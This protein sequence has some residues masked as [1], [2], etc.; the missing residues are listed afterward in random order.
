MTTNTTASEWWAEGMSRKPG[1]S[2]IRVSLSRAL[3][4]AEIEFFKGINAHSDGSFRTRATAN[5][6][7]HES[8]V[9]D[10]REAYEVLAWLLG[11]NF[12]NV[13]PIAV[14]TFRELV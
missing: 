3:T 12:V 8:Y 10:S 6:I 5:R 4:P 13:F 11:E 1:P 7:W 2:R 9:Q 14:R